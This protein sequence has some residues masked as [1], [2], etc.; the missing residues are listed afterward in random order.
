MSAVAFTID[1]T[2][3]LQP[4]TMPISVSQS[5]PVYHPAYQMF[6]GLLAVIIL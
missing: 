1:T 5:L 2:R 6:A 4:L 3:Y